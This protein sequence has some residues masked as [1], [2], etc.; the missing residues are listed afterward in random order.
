MYTIQKAAALLGITEQT[1]RIWMKQIGIKSKIIVTDQR[2]AYLTDD[3]METLI[4][5]FAQKTAK[6]GG[7]KKKKK[8]NNAE[9]T[10]NLDTE[11]HPVNK[12]EKLYSVIGAASAL[13]VSVV[14][15]RQWINQHNIDAKVI[16]T[17]RKRLYISYKDVLRLADLHG[18]KKIK[19]VPADINSRTESN[20][21]PD[22][23]HKLYSIA[24]AALFLDASVLTVKK[25]VRQHNIEKTTK[26]TDRSRAYIAYKDILRLADL[27]K[28]KIVPA[29]SPFNVVEEIKELKRKLNALACEVED[30]KH[31]FRIYVK[32]SIYIGGIASTN[33]QPNAGNS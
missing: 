13:G 8:S 22:D 10:V 32:R 3:D 9:I 2:R 24:E 25:W 18:I 6:R 11:Y 26:S 15:I 30:I 5:H 23:M 29:P 7:K 12:Q 33:S 1:I 20:N 21:T 14:A 17:D 31:D 4:D 19:N 27:H 16:N 28:R